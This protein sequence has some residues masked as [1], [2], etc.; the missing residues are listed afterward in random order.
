MGSVRQALRPNDIPHP[1]I[2]SPEGEGSVRSALAFVD[3]RE[4]G[5]DHVF[6]AC[7]RIRTGRSSRS[8]LLLV[9]RLTHLHRH[10]GQCLGLGFHRFQIAAF[11][12]SL[13]LGQRTFDLALERGVDLVAVLLKL[14]LGGVDQAVGVVA[15]FRFFAPFLVFLGKLLGIADHLVDIRIARAR[16]K[17]GS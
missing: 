8:L 11:N 17:P 9:D 2:P 16:P 10:F 13:G 3:F 14:T 1:S 12:R 6:V 4:F 15:G 7:R 5:I